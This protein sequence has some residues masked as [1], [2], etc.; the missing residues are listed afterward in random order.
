MT[1]QADPNC[2][3]C[4]I[5]AGEIPAKKV[6]ED[7]EV[8]AFHDIRPVAPVHLLVIPKHHIP[9]TKELTDADAGWMGRLMVAATKVALAAGCADGWR[10]IINTGRIGRQE[11]MH[12]HVHLLGGGNEPLP[13]M[14]KR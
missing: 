8:L 12:L 7:E 4:K 11:V 5:V 14:L 3:F 13:I 6:Y 10:T 2:V 1:T 9:S